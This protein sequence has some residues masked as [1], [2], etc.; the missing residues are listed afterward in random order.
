MTFGRVRGPGRHD[1]R[2]GVGRHA[3]AGRVADGAGLRHARE[4]DCLFR[5][6]DGHLAPFLPGDAEGAIAARPRHQVC[7]DARQDMEHRIGHAQLPL[8]PQRAIFET[9]L[10]RVGAEH[11]AARRLDIAADLLRH[12]AEELG[13]GIGA[14]GGTDAP[15]TP[16]KPRR[17]CATDRSRSLQRDARSQPSLLEGLEVL[18][19]RQ[20]V[21]LGQVGAVEMALVAV[22][23]AEAG[24]DRCRSSPAHRPGSRPR[25]RH[26]RR[27]R[28][29]AP[30]RPARSCAGSQTKPSASGS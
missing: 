27:S 5:E 9:L 28:T 4:A 7:E 13:P 19:Q 30:A 25:R 23:G 22:A 8:R 16:R 18:D 2:V 14:A 17:S 1:H 11:G 10:G 29:G 26:G 21:G 6:A 12:L 20:L 24:R 15:A 3:I